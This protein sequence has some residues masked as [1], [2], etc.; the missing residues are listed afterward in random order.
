M[1]VAELRPPRA[2]SSIVP[3]Q[4][5]EFT[6]ISPVFRPG[7]MTVTHE[8]VFHV[9]PFFSVRF[10][11]P[12]LPVPEIALPN[13]QLITIRPCSRDAVFPKC[14]LVLQRLRR[15]SIWHAKQMD[16][17]WHEDLATHTPEIPPLP[18]VNNAFHGSFICQQTP[19]SMCANGQK[20][21]DGAEAG[22]DGWKMGWCFSSIALEA[23]APAS[24]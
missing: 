2:G 3:F 4:N 13:R 6:L 24:R 17:V 1:G 11:A 14:D 19:S 8:I 15:E 23:R 7:Y 12:Q 21:K 22:F 20:N 16:V 5:I 18:G 10:S 9:F